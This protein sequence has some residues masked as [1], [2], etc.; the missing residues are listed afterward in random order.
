MKKHHRFPC[1]L[2]VLAMFLCIVL[3]TGVIG[4]GTA[5][6]A[7]SNPDYAV[8]IADELDDIYW[9][10]E[11]TSKD[12]EF[13]FKFKVTNY[14]DSKKDLTVRLIWEEKAAGAKEFRQTE[15]V[16]GENPSY[17]T[18][19]VGKKASVTEDKKLGVVSDVGLTDSKKGMIYRCRIELL[20][21]EGNAIQTIYTAE[22]R[23]YYAAVLGGGGMSQQESV[24]GLPGHSL[25]TLFPLMR[26]AR[27]GTTASL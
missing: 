22:R 6:A 15:M 4:S 26:E 10:D 25:L 16:T 5:Y 13:E 24:A 23:L 18:L 12:I 21:S 2:R 3:V 11:P 19:S 27:R 17:V 14:T 20:D 9:K 8:S 1:S 7:P